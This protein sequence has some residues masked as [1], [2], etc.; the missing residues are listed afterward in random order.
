MGIRKYIFFNLAAFWCYFCAYFLISLYRIT[1]YSHCTE[2]DIICP[3][4]FEFILLVYAYLLLIYLFLIG[5]FEVVIRKFT[6]KLIIEKY[7]Q[8]FK[9]NLNI[10]IPKFIV[11]PYNVLFFIGFFAGVINILII[12][13]FIALA[14]L[15]GNPVS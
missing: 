15:L 1:K 8:N 13:L 10:K 2:E 7:F 11:I 4:T 12:L 5:F 9:L 6:K 14:C 3:G